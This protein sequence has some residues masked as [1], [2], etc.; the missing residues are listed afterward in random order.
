MLVSGVRLRF[1]LQL[2]NTILARLGRLAT[3]T[4]WNR[5]VSENLWLQHLGI[6]GVGGVVGSRN[7]WRDMNSD[8]II[9]WSSFDYRLI[10]IHWCAGTF[11]TL[12]RA[13]LGWTQLTL[14]RFDQVWLLH[15]VVPL[16]G[17][18]RIYFAFTSYMFEMLAQRFL[19]VPCCN[20]FR[21]TSNSIIRGL[22]AMNCWHVATMITLYATRYKSAFTLIRMMLAMLAW[23]SIESLRVPLAEFV[24]PTSLEECLLAATSAKHQDNPILSKA[25]LHWPC[26]IVLILYREF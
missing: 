26:R 22:M 15:F 19:M 18:L 5:A 7:L 13:D 12:C 9:V 4:R 20:I 11:R 10:M 3:E 24:A 2:C 6:S 23:I 14:D 17:L 8:G 16:R 21:R 1:M 25:P